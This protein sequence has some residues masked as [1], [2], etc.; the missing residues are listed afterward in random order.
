MPPQIHR[1]R[2]HRLKPSKL[3]KVCASRGIPREAQP[4]IYL[5]YNS[6][7]I[8]NSYIS[9]NSYNS[10]FSYLSY[11]SRLLRGHTLLE[12]SARGRVKHHIERSLAV[13]E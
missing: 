7:L 13:G 9:Y 6:Y 10:Y 4:F 2:H 11:N 12:D 3:I 1:I 8:Y 5:S